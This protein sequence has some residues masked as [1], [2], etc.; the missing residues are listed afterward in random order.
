MRK[1]SPK[2]IGI[3]VDVDTTKGGLISLVVTLTEI[4]RDAL[5]LQAERIIEKKDILNE[6]EKERLKAAFANLEDVI[7]ELKKE[8]DIVESVSEMR[9]RLNKS[10]AFKDNGDKDDKSY[11]S[12]V[13][14][15]DTILSKGTVIYGNIP[16]SIADIILANIT[17]KAALAGGV[18]MVEQGLMQDE[19]LHLGRKV[20]SKVPLGKNERVIS[21]TFGSYWAKELQHPRWQLGRFYFTDRRFFLF[22]PELARISFETT[23]EAIEGWSIKVNT[24]YGKGREELILFFKNKGIARLHSKDTQGLKEMVEERMREKGLS[25]EE[26]SYHFPEEERAKFLNDGEKIIEEEPIWSLTSSSRTAQQ[27]GAGTWKRGSLYLTDKRLLWQDNI[28]KK[29]VFEFL[30]SEIS[31]VTIEVRDFSFKGALKDQRPL[32]KKALIISSNGRESYFSED[33]EKIQKWQK[34]LEKI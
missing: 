34:L 28:T 16:L 9:E 10:F 7:E 24:K 32:Y 17:L 3:N 15:L 25:F 23:Y 31:K 8:Q 6:E 26:L 33:E 30:R 29:I 2:G 14:T 22:K 4:L 21:S 20:E 19:E 12:L 18:T 5:K 27:M 13:N 1:S 11:D